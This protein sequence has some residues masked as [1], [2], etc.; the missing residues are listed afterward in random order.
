VTTAV[1]PQDTAALDAGTYEVLRGRLGAQARELAERAD[2]LNTRRVA[3]FGGQQMRLLGTER[4]RTPNS[5]VPR[6]V[7]QVGGA[8]LL[9]YNVFIGLKAETSVTDVFAVH[10]FARDGDA[11]R[12]DPGVTVPGLLDDPAFQREFAELYRYYR[13]TRLLQLRRLEGLL[14]AVFQTGATTSRC[15]AGR[16]ASTARWRTWT[17][18]A[19]ATTSSRRR[20]TSSGRS[21]PANSTSSG[22]TRTSRSTTRCSSRRW[23]ARSP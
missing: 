6:D 3:T 17:T 9:G 15:C 14:L 20:T 16:S 18:A 21:P 23:A 11:F 2:E 1:A 8:M 5:C 12:F 19:N 4:I 22:G 10:G 13:E 7:V